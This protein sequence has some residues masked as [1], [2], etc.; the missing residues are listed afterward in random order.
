MTR[1]R[2][3]RDA[4][5]HTYDTHIVNLYR[6]MRSYQTPGTVTLTDQD[7]NT[8]LQWR[9]HLENRR[10]TGG[11]MEAL[12]EWATKLESSVLRLC[13]LLH[14]AHHGNHHGNIQPGIIEKAI[15]IGNY[16]IEHAYAVHDLWGT[17]E[18]LTKAR[19]ILNWLINDQA[20]T[21]F[22]I[23]ELQK[24]LRRHVDRVADALEPVTILIERGWIRPM[25]E[26]PIKVGARGRNAQRFQIHPNAQTHHSRHSRS[27][28]P[29]NDQKEAAIR[30]ISAIRVDTKSEEITHS[31]KTSAP[32]D[33]AQPTNGAGC[34]NDANG[35]NGDNDDLNGYEL[36]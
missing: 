25:F 21:D 4:Q 11:D 31:L 8:Y 24:G 33:D 3:N 6:T 15:Q 35:A 1:R 19:L 16:W 26:G 20:A 12:A 34:A 5:Q 23:S 29:E 36:I 30:A 14:I 9:Q 18:N 10:D 22:S 17:D 7:A 27:Q 2:T 28:T 32:T 13:G